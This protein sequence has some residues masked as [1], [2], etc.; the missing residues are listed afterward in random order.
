MDYLRTVIVDDVTPTPDGTH[1]YDVVV[2]P[3]S[4]LIFTIKCLNVTDEASI[5][6]I[7]ALVPNIELLHRGT[8]I[9]QMCAA[10]LYA[11][12]IVLFGKAPIALNQVADDNAVRTLSLIVPMGRR[13][14]D[15]EECYPETKSGE[16]ILK[17]TVDIE[18]LEADGLMLQVEAVELLAAR[19]RRHIKAG[20]LQRQPAATGECDV[21][22]PMQNIYAGLLLYSTTIPTAT[23]WTSTIESVKL[24]ANNTERLFSYSKWESLR[25]DLIDRPGHEPGHIA[26]SGDDSIAHYA[27]MDF[28]P[29]G[30]DR[31][32]LDTKPLSD[33]TLRILGGDSNVVRVIPVELAVA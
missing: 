5:A 16:L 11:L 33:L 24:L 25:G 15:P 20:T 31:F 10:D 3:L 8:T 1:S 32:L 22:L 30:D 28:C 9:I 4:H 27:Y 12:N 2:N 18:T 17:A 26:A 21:D 19:P 23:T 6:H 7:C 14:Y 29:H 13:T